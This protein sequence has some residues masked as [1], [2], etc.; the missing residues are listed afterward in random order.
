MA[1]VQHLPDQYFQRDTQDLKEEAKRRKV[2]S[3]RMNSISGDTGCVL[4]FKKRGWFRERV[5]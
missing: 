3:D 5:L 4:N 2:G 1:A